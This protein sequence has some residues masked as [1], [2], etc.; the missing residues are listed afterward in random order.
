[1]IE[2]SAIEAVFFDVDDTLVDYD[3]AARA[4]F[5]ETFGPD[6]DFALWLEASDPHFARYGRGEVDFQQMREDRTADFLERLGRQVGR[7]EVVQ[8]ERGRFELTGRSY[9]LFDDA[10]P[11]L[12]ALRERGLRL[13]LITNN[14][15]V[16][17]RGKLAHVGL[18]DGFDAVVISGEVGVAKPDPAIFA[19]ACAA[20]G[21]APEHALHVGDR[22]E[23]DAIA[24]VAAGLTGVW[25]DRRRAHDGAPLS[26]PI[27]AGLGELPDLVG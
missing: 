24:A 14:E 12:Q 23:L 21:V 18:A 7:A 2:V 27:I 20:V 11:C 16:H 4:A 10:L 6:Q 9:Q 19:H 5:H 13:G 3:R 26:V 15:P 22:L 1:M 17:Q 25:L 8:I